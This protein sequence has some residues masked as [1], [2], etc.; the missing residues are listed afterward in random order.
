LLAEVMSAVDD[1]ADFA[2]VDSSLDSLAFPM[3]PFA[4]LELVGMGVAAHVVGAMHQSFPD[5]FAH[6]PTLDALAA[7]GRR[8]VY[9]EAGAPAIDPEVSALVPQRETPPN[10]EQIRDRVL[11]ALAQEVGLMLDEGVV[12]SPADIDL[13]M[14][15]GAGWPFWLG[16]ITPYLDRSGVSQ[17]VRGKRFHEGLPDASR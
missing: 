2:T 13:C 3:A 12:S 8:T 4:L 7:S 1:G 17:D 5:R 9:A 11:R 16:G 14:V 15:L 10:G 6:S